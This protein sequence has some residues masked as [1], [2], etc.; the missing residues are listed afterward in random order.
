MKLIF[1]ADNRDVKNFGCRAT[2]IALSQ[3]LIRN[4]DI[5]MTIYRKELTSEAF[6][7][8][9]FNRFLYKLISYLP[10]WRCIRKI[11][12][13]LK[14]R[15]RIFKLPKFNDYLR[16]N[17]EI[18]VENFYKCLPANEHLD[19]MDLRKYDFDG[20]VVNG[21]GT[22]IFTTPPRRDTLVYL[23]MVQ[24]A[25]KLNKRVFFVNA[26]FSRGPLTKLNYQTIKFTEKTLR[27][28]EIVSTRDDVSLEFINEHMPKIS[29]I[30][31][32]D[33]LFGW[34]KIVQYSEISLNLKYFTPAG[35]ESN[36]MFTSY[37]I[38]GP[39]IIISGSSLATRFKKE[40]IK[41]YVNLVNE[42]KK[43]KS[44]D[45][46]L[47]PTCSGDAFLYEVSRITN[48][49]IIP[50]EINIIILGRILQNSKLLISGRYH[51]SIM[52]SLGEVKCIF[53]KSNSHKTKSLQQLLNYEKIVEFTSTPTLEEIR[54]I[55]IIANKLLDETT[56]YR[57]ELN[58]RVKILAKESL[59]IAEFI[60]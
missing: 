30:R 55:F 17:P 27:H 9:L 28:S 38:K 3:L 47:M 20:L 11:I 35:F 4:N 50:L 24:Q 54:K 33:A 29:A 16:Y 43:I 10:K 12:L 45:I 25:I 18:S 49:K 44:Y 42:I 41:S 34:N 36:E 52:A 1:I 6:Y 7:F 39:Y 40:A 37:N 46:Y 48:T 56:N 60:S 15:L 22:M 19:N 2:S 23:M 53:L 13:I 59:K 58:K 14:S 8:F 26:M 32:P 31:V 21:E 57:A 51:P 5:V